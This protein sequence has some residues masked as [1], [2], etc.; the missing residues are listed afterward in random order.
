MMFMT[1]MFSSHVLMKALA[2]S[3]MLHINRAWF[4]MY[5]T[6][7]MSLYFCYKLARG[8]MRYW[9]RIDGVWSV[10]L[11]VVVRFMVKTIA[12]FTLLVQFRHPF[13]LGFYWSVNVI[14]NQA[15]C[16]ISIF[17]YSKYSEN[18]SDNKVEALWKLVFGLFFF[19]MLNFGIFLKLINQKYVKTFFSSGSGKQFCANYFLEGTTD[20]VKWCVFN[21]HRSYFAAIEDDLKQWL[22][23]NWERLEEEQPEW[24]IP[25]WIALV[26][27]DMLPKAALK[28]MGGVKGRR[29]SID[30]MKKESKQGKLESV[31]RGS[32]LKII[33]EEERGE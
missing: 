11:S 26:P 7:D 10:V 21:H 18:V 30:N 24:F 15:F 13:E 22:D 19:S 32:D 29:E 25:S 3:L 27:S 12:D 2:C 6:A 4:T 28:A 5:L 16:F 31:R 20:K 8:E 1:F 9:L 14:L 17:L 23:E 33:Q